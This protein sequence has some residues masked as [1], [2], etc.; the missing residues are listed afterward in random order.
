MVIGRLLNNM[1]SRLDSGLFCNFTSFKGIDF[2]KPDIIHEKQLTLLKKHLQYCKNKSPY[3]KNILKKI[4]PDGISFEKFIDLPFT[5][6]SDLEKY[7]KEFLSVPEKKIIDI[8]YSSG[9]MGEITQIMY[10]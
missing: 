6:K 7:N 1:N 9:T 4:N 8:V 2:L 10:T 5:N 3:Y